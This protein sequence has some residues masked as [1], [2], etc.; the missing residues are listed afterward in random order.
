MEKQPIIFHIDVNSAFLSWEANYRMHTLGETV[1]IRTIPAVIGGSEAERHGIV[2]AKST[3]ARRYKIQTGEP[4]A[5]ARKKC[6]N[7]V[8]VP[9]TYSVYVDSSRRFVD[10]LK[11]FT[12][13]VEPYSI[14]EVF[15][16]FT[17]TE[18]LYGKP[19]IWARQLADQIRDT[20][21]FTVNIGISSNRLLAKM[22]SDFEKPDKVHTLFPEE[23][24]AKMWP[25]DIRELFF[26]GKASEQK[27]RTLGIHT[28]GD[29]ARTDR[30]FLYHHLKK[31]GETIWDFAHGIDHGEI[32]KD[33]P[34][35]NKGY[36]NSITL[37]Y[38][39][40][41]PD[42]ARVILL[43][44]CETVGARIRADKTYIGVVGVTITD[45]NFHHTSHQKALSTATDI[46][47]RIY[48]TACE[49]F[50]ELWTGTPIRLLGV[51]TSRATE[52]QSFQYTLFDSD[53]YQRLSRL[54]KA[55]D[56][57]RGKYGEDSVQR[58]CF[59][60]SRQTHMSG[61]IGKAKR[62][63]HAKRSSVDKE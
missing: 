6:P 56:A 61:G 62:T 50:D 47:Y 23:I 35:Q 11:Q 4:L 40:T 2:L 51:F 7:L 5:H 21:G 46:T 14:D 36:G 25:L 12:P 29:L 63:E 17:G 53:K 24:P 13:D 45:H 39:V 42:A 38:D 27:L 33:A 43:S 15:C 31:H 28:I 26:V 58:A 10:Y 57:I 32:T 37:S 8:I 49:L 54:D 1:D 18:H 9:P 16:D 44:L 20:L 34:P 60:K 55:I 30:D 48:E 59:I 52:D 19:E 41:D 22:A 3:P